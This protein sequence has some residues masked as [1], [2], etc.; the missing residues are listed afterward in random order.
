MNELCECDPLRC[1]SIKAHVA[2]N[3]ARQS[4]TPMTHHQV[5]VINSLSLYCL[6]YSFPFLSLPF[7]KLSTA[8]IVLSYMKRVT[9]TVLLCNGMF[10]GFN[11]N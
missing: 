4:S 3:M 11:S 9:I 10:H 5:Q 6:F 1:R 2:L 8:G 7:S